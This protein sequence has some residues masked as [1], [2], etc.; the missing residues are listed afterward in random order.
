MVKA[1]YMYVLNVE[2]Q[3]YTWFNSSAF[4]SGNTYVEVY[5][6]FVFLERRLVAIL[7]CCCR[8]VQS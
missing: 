6:N 8:E 1:N 7:L 3:L 4:Y 5:Y 2:E